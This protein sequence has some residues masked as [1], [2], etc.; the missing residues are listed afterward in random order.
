MS[1]ASRAVQSRTA[2]NLPMGR[3]LSPRAA[4]W[5]IT[6]TPPKDSKNDITGNR[7]SLPLGSVTI[8]LISKKDIITADTVSALI[9]NIRE[10]GSVAASMPPESFSIWSI[11][12]KAT[13]I[14]HI[15]IIAFDAER[16]EGISMASFTVM[17]FL[18]AFS[19]LGSRR[20]S[21][22][23]VSTFDDIMDMNISTAALESG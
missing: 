11:P 3:S 4:I 8:L 14:M 16:T 9:S 18:F 22:N 12:P 6:H 1:A 2:M 21:I 23:A 17:L 15:C 7:V 10:A 20:V 13:I 19:S 5:S